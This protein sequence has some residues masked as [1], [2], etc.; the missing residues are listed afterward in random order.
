MQGK[1]KCFERES[2]QFLLQDVSFLS[3][4]GVDTGRLVHALG[5]ATLNACL[6][7]LSQS[8]AWMTKTTAGRSQPELSGVGESKVQ[9]LHGCSAVTSRHI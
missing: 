1:L 3:R 4:T 5:A 8:H 7:N 6:P 2:F 9:R